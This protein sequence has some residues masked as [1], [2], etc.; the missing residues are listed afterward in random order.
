MPYPQTDYHIHSNLSICARDSMTVDAIVRQ[1]EKR[2]FESIAITDHVDVP[3]ER[4]RCET[5]AEELR[6]LRPA[7]QVLVGCE[8]EAFSTDLPMDEAF[9]STLDFV[10]IA[11][12]HFHAFPP[13][14]IP[15]D[16]M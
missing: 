10:L 3:E 8:I 12:N 7:I 14:D 5:I 15:E 1:A 6:K 13:E 9:A 4:A 16:T 2:K 11:P